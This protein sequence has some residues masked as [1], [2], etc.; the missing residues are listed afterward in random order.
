MRLDDKKRVSETLVQELEGAG[1]IYLTDFTGLDVKAITEFRARLREQ[2]IG[3]RV[4]KNT[5][6]RRALAALDLP[7]ELAGH[8]EGPTGLVLGHDDPVA[9]AKIV[10]E[11]AKAHDEKPVLKIG[12]VERRTVMPDAIR[13][14]ADLPPRD[15]LLGAI[16]GS[17]TAGV[18][19]I[20]GALS[21][22]LR[23]VTY[24]IEQVA[25]RNE[26]A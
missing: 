11:F 17:L 14:M 1:I 4:V 26:A 21:A 9:P 16:A 22:L 15:E 3:Y 12:V 8:L 23:D 18:A 19:G 10:K 6:M 25:R 24:M 7:G 2:G 20:A 5:L 13:Q